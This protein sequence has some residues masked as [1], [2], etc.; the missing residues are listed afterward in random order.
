MNE[1]STLIIHIILIIIHIFLL[2]CGAS[3]STPPLPSPP[4][5]C[6][7]ELVTF[8]PCLP[9]ISAFPNNISEIP[10]PQCCDDVSITFASGSAVCLCYLVRRPGIL[11]FPLNYTKLMSITSVCPEKRHGSKAN[12]SLKFLCSESA[13]LPP[14]NSVT[15]AG[16]PAPSLMGSAQ[17]S[18]NASVAPRPSNEL[19]IQHRNSTIPARISSATKR[20]PTPTF[21]VIIAFLVYNC[22][23]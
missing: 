14:L 19:P 22:L 1:S 6:S 16:S 12:F 13:T 23:Y 7:D 18:S 5:T 20:I 3:V 11:G 8:S 2:R 15:G 21:P 17:D 4:V 9:Y 10:P